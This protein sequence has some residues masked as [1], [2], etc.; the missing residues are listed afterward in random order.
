MSTS[1]FLSDVGWKDVAAKNK[2]KDNGLLKELAD[3]KRLADDKLDDQLDSLDQILKLATQLKKAKDVAAASSA[4][5]YVGDVIDAAETERRVVVK[6]KAD[7]AKDKAEAEKKAKAET[8]KHDEK[9]DEEEEETSALLTTKMVPLLRQ[10]AKG[11]MMH[12]LVASAGKEVV[13]MVS[14]KPIS[15]SRRKL[16]ADQLGVS[17]GVK[18]FPCHCI[19]EEGTTTF[20]LKT[21]VVGMAKKLKLALLQQT[22]LRV[23]LRCRGEDGD[24][25]EDLEEPAEQR[26]AL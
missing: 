19:R 11:E 1:K 7:K 14:R 3:Y 8:D 18:Y 21:E 16:L 9:D 25:D 6:A 23:K 4:V 15:P 22:G 2:V 10:V 12:T 5:K 17:G 13:A 26:E 24:T 20:V